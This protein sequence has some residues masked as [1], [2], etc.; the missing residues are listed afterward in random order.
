[1]TGKVTTGAVT[2]R[3]VG[4][5][6][7]GDLRELSESSPQEYLEDNLR[8]E[9]PLEPKSESPEAPD[10]EDTDSPDVESSPRLP[11]TRRREASERAKR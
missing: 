1:M 7:G 10:K 2:G 8:R 9:L 11:C 4:A 3:I 5:G 6:T